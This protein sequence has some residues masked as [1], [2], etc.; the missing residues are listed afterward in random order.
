MLVNIARM[1]CDTGWAGSASK[2]GEDEAEL[3]GGG[4][5]WAGE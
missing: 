1:S 4:E 2:P 3:V 5:V